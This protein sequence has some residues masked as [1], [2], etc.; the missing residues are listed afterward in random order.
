MSEEQSSPIK[1]NPDGSPKLVEFKFSKTETQKLQSILN[2]ETQYTHEGIKSKVTFEL[3]SN[4]S[5]RQ[6]LTLVDWSNL[7]IYSQFAHNSQHVM[8]GEQINKFRMDTSDVLGELIVNSI[9]EYKRKSRR[10]VSVDVQMEQID[11]EG[12]PHIRIM[13]MDKGDGYPQDVIDKVN[14]NQIDEPIQSEK[15]ILSAMDNPKR[16]NGLNKSAKFI[17]E[18]L[19][20]QFYIG[21]RVEGGSY[22][23]VLIPLE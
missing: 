8:S 6:E 17:R 12:K 14:N 11:F 23:G 18:T 1:F 7:D 9:E 2:V 4:L 15:K 13:V 19:H 20:G 16:G 3:D 5:P 10:L 22:A 21:N